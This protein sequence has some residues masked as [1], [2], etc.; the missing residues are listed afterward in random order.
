VEASEVKSGNLRAVVVGYA[1]L[2]ASSYFTLAQELKSPTQETQRK[3]TEV[4]VSESREILHGLNEHGISFQGLFVYDWSKEFDYD[5]DPASGFGRYS[6]DLSMPVD[7]KK[8]FGLE[9]SAGFVRLKHHLRNF[10]ETDEGAAQVYSNIDAQ[11]RTTLYEIWFEQRLVAN[12]LRLKGGKI[13]ANTEF[14]TVQ[15]AGDFLNSSMGYSPTI[16]SFPTYPEPKLGINAFLHP[17]ANYGL[18]LGWFQTAGTGTLFVIEPGVNWNVGQG[19]HPGRASVGYWRLNGQVDRFDGGY[20]AGTQGFYA[21]VEQSGW[22]H[23]WV[24]AHGERKLSTFLQFGEGPGELSAITRHVGGGGVLQ[25]P[26]GKRWQD[27]IGIAASWV[28][29]SS[30]PGAGFELG[31][32]LA[33]ESYYK[34]NFTRHVAFVQDFQFLRHPGGMRANPDCPVITPRLVISF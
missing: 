33:L 27:S 4:L 11:S 6:F 17:T 13:D 19:E 32:E 9:G 5:D 30:S 26:F 31:G 16:M 7:G 3:A 23:P 34:A 1:V 24:G 14:A 22:Q 10:G 28:Q 29:F 8:A 25:A 12:K 18:G 15:I 2:L 20:E 21:V